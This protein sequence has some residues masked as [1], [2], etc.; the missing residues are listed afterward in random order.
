MENQNGLNVLS[1]FDGISCG[2]I[3][4]DRAGIKVNK[5]FASEIDKHA[6]KVT[7]HNWPETV[8]LGSVVDVKAENLPKI[9]LLCGGS[10]CQSF[11]IAGNGEGFDGKS[12]LFFEWLRLFKE[13]NP[14]YFLLENVL[15]KKEWEDKITE[16]VGAKPVMISSAKFSAQ[17]RE[18]LYWTNIPFNQNIPDNDIFLNNILEKNVDF[19]YFLE[20]SYKLKSLKEDK[21]RLKILEE[22]YR[23]SYKTYKQVPVLVSEVTGDTPS[24]RSRQT[25]R[26]YSALSKS[27]TLLANRACDLKIDCGSADSKKWR[28]LTP[29]EAERLQTVPEGYTS[30]VANP[31]RFKCLGNGWTVDV[32]AHIFKGLKRG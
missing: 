13:T 32:I 3:A 23:V 11:S 25:D 28:T 18:R 1:L 22:N 16:L 21:S 31:Q 5:Y 9:D 12:G 27:P 8:Q 4:L 6:I 20:N 26:L 29:L 14:K 7:Q 17:A 10:P 15:M 30:C 2:R 24:G 19:C